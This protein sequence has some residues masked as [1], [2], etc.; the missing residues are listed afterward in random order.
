VANAA[1]A[2]LERGLP[3]DWL[4]AVRHALDH[5]T[6]GLKPPK[7][8]FRET[9]MGVAAVTAAMSDHAAGRE[10]RPGRAVVARELGISERTVTRSWR[11]LE[12]RGLLIPTGDGRH[13]DPQERAQ[14][15]D[16]RAERNTKRAAAG[17]PPLPD[18]GPRWAARANWTLGLP[19]WLREL[20][21]ADLT[22]CEGAATA[23]LSA[24]TA[25]GRTDRQR[26][27]AHRR[28]EAKSVTPSPKGLRFGSFL[29]VRRT[30]TPSRPDGREEHKGA[31]SRPSPAKRTRPGIVGHFGSKGPFE[32]YELARELALGVAVPMLRGLPGWRVRVLARGL[33]ERG[34]AHWTV[35]D[36]VDRVEQTIRA[37]WAL[38]AVV[39]DPVALLLS[40]L[41]GAVPAA[42]PAQRR[43]AEQAAATA[44]QRERQ[45]AARVAAAEQAAAAVPAAAVPV[46]VAARAGLPS[47]RLQPSP[48]PPV[49]PAPA[50]PSSQPDPSLRGIA[51]ARAVLAAAAAR[52][53]ATPAAP[54]AA[55][56]P[57]PLVPTVST[58]ASSP[59]PVGLAQART[60][61]QLR[62]PGQCVMCDSTGPDVRRRATTTGAPLVAC[63]QHAA[64]LAG[65]DQP[66]RKERTP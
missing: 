20:D 19:V 2:A 25:G 44:A 9:I 10:A 31:A 56:L 38:P 11:A 32:A 63:D 34:L 30:K 57:P 18:R 60:R 48:P 6:A 50:P 66:N 49:A 27:L 3:V 47:P 55:L 36:I 21:L 39:I 51:L 52:R 4:A 46:Y 13:L 23:A 35:A 15:V 64:W 17:L 7:R 62:P 43:L 5:V 41:N 28:P 40:R 61:A 54:A 33:G 42:P 53:E 29:P 65:N 37:G 26:V 58:A 14:L 12:A 45:A 1:E 8:D 59:A 24:L 22:R 16:E